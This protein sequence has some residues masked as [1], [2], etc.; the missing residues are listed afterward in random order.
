MGRRTAGL[1]DC[2]KLGGVN[3]GVELATIWANVGAG[4][5][6]GGKLL[7]SLWESF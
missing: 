6:S 3:L 1:G 5:G 7:E 4:V 2:T